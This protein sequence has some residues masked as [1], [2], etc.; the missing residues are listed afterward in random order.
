MFLKS[1]RNE[2]LTFCDHMEN[3][4][5]TAT[6]QVGALLKAQK[7]QSFQNMLKPFIKTQIKVSK[8]SKISC[9]D[10]WIRLF[11]NLR[12]IFPALVKRKIVRI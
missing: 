11:S 9:R 12:L 10:E 6:S 8:H 2:C 7:A 5:K 1:P 3:K 4:N